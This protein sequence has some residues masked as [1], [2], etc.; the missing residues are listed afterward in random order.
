MKTF[1]QD[2]DLLNLKICCTKYLTLAPVFE[3]LNLHGFS[4]AN[5]KGEVL[6]LYAFE[7]YGQRSYGDIDILVSRKNLRK[8]EDILMKYGYTSPTKTREEKILMLS[9]SHQTAAWSKVINC[10]C[11]SVVDVNF[12]LFWGEYGG[13]R[14]DIDQFLLDTIEMEIYGMR[15]KTLSPLKAMVQIILHHYKEM[16]SIYH[17][18]EHDCIRYSMFRDVYFLWK[19]NDGMISLDNLYA[20]SLEYEIIPYVFYI[21]YFT[22]E[23]FNDYELSRYIA[24]FR[25]PEGISL[26]DC[27][28]L[29]EHERKLWKVDFQ[30]R[31]ET[32][33][34][35]DLIKNDLTELDLEKLERN[36]KI[37][38]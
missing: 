14:I 15:I 25:T 26:L 29:T 9:A 2:D 30:T 24:A 7:Q 37:F 3:E 31:L 35:Y 38:G 19:N 12:D 16:N 13:H 27:Y 10:K 28:G 1:K 4:Y 5:I 20:L 17:I 32:K 36:R 34:L 18:A 6:S 22:N 23:I 11:K 33:N 21:L 8:F